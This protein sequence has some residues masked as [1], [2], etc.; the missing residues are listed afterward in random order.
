MTRID[1]LNPLSTSRTQHGNA[2]AAVDSASARGRDGTERV[3]G[4][5]D[6]ISLSNRG[7]VVADAARAVADSP[8]V[9]ADRV[10]ALKAAIAD[11]S[12]RS[13]AR[14]IA[15]RL[16]ASGAFTLD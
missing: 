1:G 10:A 3:D 2:A 8:E 4:P 7:R 16:V 12:Y 9:R 15:T 14:D 13:N 6:A 11:G 5:Q